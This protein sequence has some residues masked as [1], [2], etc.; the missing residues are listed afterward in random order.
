MPL[1]QRDGTASCRSDGPQNGVARTFCRTEISESTGDGFNRPNLQNQAYLQSAA[2]AARRAKI[3]KGDDPRLSPQQSFWSKPPPPSGLW[4]TDDVQYLDKVRCHMWIRMT[5]I[6]PKNGRYEGRIKCHWALRTLNS[7]ERTEPRIRVP[8][9]RLPR[10]V[11]AIEESRIWRHFDGDSERTV[12]WQGTT[13]LSFAGFEMFEV[14]EFPFDRQVI[15]LDLFEFVWRSDKDSDQYFEAMKVVSFTTETISMLPEWD[16]YPAVIEPLNIKKPGSGPSYGTRFTVKL[17]LQRREK[18]YITQ[19]F[20]VT[21]LILSA[22]LLPLALAPG[23]TFVGDRLSLHSSGLLTLVAFKYSVSNEL[24]TV[25]YTTCTSTWLTLQIATL[26]SCCCETIFAYK[27]TEVIEADVLNV[28]EDLLLYVLLLGWLIYFLHI[29]FVKGRVPWDEILS[30]QQDNKELKDEQG[31]WVLLPNQLPLD[32][33][34]WKDPSGDLSAD[35]TDTTDMAHLPSK[36]TDRT[37]RH[38]PDK[39]DRSP[40]VSAIS[41]G[42]SRDSEISLPMHQFQL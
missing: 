29:A 32:E 7:K 21:Y 36:L 10:L 16:T 39:T 35:S 33:E 15:N 19:I 13:V 31:P 40:N 12:A 24:P 5:H 20:M 4:D 27:I 18:Y 11:C 1:P 42:W 25:P 6:D 26:V 9:L 41:R 2:S 23:D 22:S 3:V 8:G 17:R 37:D 28:I 30:S 14:N 38:A 34:K